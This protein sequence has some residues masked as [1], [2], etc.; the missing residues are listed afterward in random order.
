M[1]KLC[2]PNWHRYPKILLTGLKCMLPILFLKINKTT[3]FIRTTNC[4]NG[5]LIRFSFFQKSWNNQ[6]MYGFVWKVSHVLFKNS[7]KN[8]PFPTRSCGNLN[9]LQSSTQ[10]KSHDWI[11][12]NQQLCDKNL[13]NIQLNC[14]RW[15]RRTDTWQVC[16]QMRAIQRKINHARSIKSMQCGPETVYKWQVVSKLLVDKFSRVKCFF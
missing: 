6:V 3:P 16:N 13:G 11:N 10:L 1:L 14:K 7:A 15:L 9:I 2:H 12:G 8:K 4:K 5:K